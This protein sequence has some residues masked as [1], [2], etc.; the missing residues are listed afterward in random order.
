MTWRAGRRR[1]NVRL[2]RVGQQIDPLDRHR[3]I[4]VV[5]IT[6]LEGRVAGDLEVITSDDGLV[7]R[8]EN[9][10]RGADREEG[11][12]GGGELHRERSPCTSGILRV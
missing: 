6:E 10:R 5:L 3:I 7:A 12:E 1:R 11:D 2:G 4:A 9:V 8:G